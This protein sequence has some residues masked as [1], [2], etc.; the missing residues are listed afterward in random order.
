MLLLGNAQWPT[1]DEAAVECLKALVVPDERIEPQRIVAQEDRGVCV[2]PAQPRLEPQ[3]REQ[4]VRATEVPVSSQS[5]EPEAEITE[6]RNDVIRLPHRSPW[7]IAAIAASVLVMIG[8]ASLLGRKPAHPMNIARID[9]SKLP[10]RAPTPMELWLISP[11]GQKFLATKSAPP[12]PAPD[13]HQTMVARLCEN[14][15]A[16]R[17]AAAMLNEKDSDSQEALLRVMLTRP[18]GMDQFLDLIRNRATRTTAMTTLAALPEPPTNALLAQLDSPSVERRFAAAKALGSLCHGQTLP[19]L[20]RMI[21]TNNH[22]RE[23]LAVLT[24]CT[25]SAAKEYVSELRRQPVM[26]SQLDV[27]HEEIKQLF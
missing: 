11:A 7:Q 25:D 9:E 16:K 8:I 20:K 13:P 15:D 17:L 19:T 4:D 3:A 12:Q 18:D 2:A 21:Q 6:A 22:Q 5:P 26:A 10:G 23:A 1:L 14:A 27:V 24:Q